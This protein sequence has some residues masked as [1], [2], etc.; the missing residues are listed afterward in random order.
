MDGSIEKPRL[1]VN[2]ELTTK[3]EEWPA[4]DIIV[5]THTAVRNIHLKGENK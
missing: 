4:E 1:Y 3:C 2:E 5:R